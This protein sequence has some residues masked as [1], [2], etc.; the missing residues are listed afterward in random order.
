MILHALPFLDDEAIVLPGH[1]KLL[2]DDDMMMVVVEPTQL[3][4]M[5]TVKLGIFYRGK[6]K[7]KN[8]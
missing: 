3:K 4:N 2:Q 1:A 6:V 5:R 8:V 7:I